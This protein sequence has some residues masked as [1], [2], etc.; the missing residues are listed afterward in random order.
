M[1]R[2]AARVAG[3]CLLVAV[4]GCGKLL[5]FDTEVSA[6]GV[7]RGLLASTGNLP[8]SIDATGSLSQAFE[9][10]GID[11]SKVQSLKITGGRLSATQSGGENHLGWFKTFEIYVSANGMDPIRIG[12]I[13][14]AKFADRAAT[15]ALIV[16]DIE[17]KPYLNAG[18]M[19]LTPK[20]ELASGS[21]PAK[22]VPVTLNMT[23]HVE[24]EI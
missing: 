16:E 18:G 17:L 11:A 7:V 1:N 13:D 24:P 5:A 20:I 8:G 12:Q 9:A 15:A 19:K 6:S 3:L 21:R 23:V 22:D 14:T 10:N 2:I 4:A